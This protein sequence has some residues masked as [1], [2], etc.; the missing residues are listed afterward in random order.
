MKP[1]FGSALLAFGWGLT[2]SV[3]SSTLSSMGSAAV[4]PPHL[5][6]RI[7]IV[8]DEVNPHGLSD[9]DLT[10]PGDLLTALTDP[11]SGLNVDLANGGVIEIATDDLEDATALLEL[12]PAS[13]DAYDVVVYFAHRI[14]T[15][16]S[17]AL[18]QQA[19]VDSLEQFLIAGGG[20]VSF[21]HGVYQTAGKES[22]QAL[23]GGTATGSV[24]W[25]TAEGQ[26]VIDVAP[27]HFVTTNG[28]EYPASTPYADPARG[29][30]SDS[31]AFFNNTPDERYL[32]FDINGNAGDVTV[33][34]ASDYD[35]SGTTHL[36][37]FE[38]R[39]PA[40]AGR[41]IVYQ[42]GEYQPN[43]ID[44]LDGN[45]FQILANAIYYSANAAG[46]PPIGLPALGPGAAI[47][48]AT[49]LLA[50]GGLV[51]RCRS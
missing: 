10:Q 35:E 18:R 27:G 39:Q 4:L 43:A 50:A 25:N 29:I 11:A 38:H 23:L 7:L 42:P 36:L 44:D 24:P 2:L 30:P 8:S 26:N 14:P 12:P 45:N 51:T 48:C 16:A 37:G 32:S 40:W 41:V 47:L 17:G 20:V 6:L 28:I 3:L 22:L 1:R 5:P 31:Y 49:L 9:A 33:L 13:P 34:F 19:F 46:S 21:H 15:G